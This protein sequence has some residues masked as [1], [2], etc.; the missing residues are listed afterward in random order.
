MASFGMSWA[1]PTAAPAAPD[2]APVA[3]KVA[4]VYSNYFGMGLNAGSYDKA[5]GGGPTSPLWTSVEEPIVTGERK[6]LKV[7]GTAFSHRLTKYNNRGVAVNSKDAGYTKVHVYVYPTTATT[8]YVYKDGGWDNADKQS[9]S[10]TPG[11]WNLVEFD[12]P[13]TWNANYYCVALMDDEDPETVFYMDDFYFTNDDSYVDDA[14][15]LGSITLPNYIFSATAGYNINAT[16]LD[17]DGA[18]FTPDA[19]LSWDGS[20]P[21]GAVINGKNIIFGAA[22]GAGIY[23]LQATDGVTTVSRKLGFVGAAPTDPTDAAGNVLAIFCGKYGTENY[24]GWGTGWEWGY[25]S[26]DLLSLGGNNCV[27]I[28]NV[29]TYGFPYPDAADLTQYTKLNFDVYTVEDV[30]GHVKIEG[31][32]ITNAEFTTTGGAW[33]HVEIDITSLDAAAGNKWIDF[34]FGANNT[35]KDRDVLID[36]IYFSKPAPADD[37]APTLQ[38]AELVG[39]GIGTVTLRLQATDN[40]AEKITYRITDQS[41]NVY[42]TKGNNGAEIT[43]TIGGLEFETAYNLTVVALDDNDNASTS[44]VVN[45]TTL[46]LTAPAA[47]TKPA[48]N[49]MSIY[50]DAYTPATTY[51]Y[52]GWG[53]STVVTPETVGGGEIVKLTNYNYLGFEYATQLDLHEMEYVHIDIL[54]M[55]TMDLGITP[56]LVAGSPTEKSTSVGA[57]TVGEWNSIDLPLSA[58]GMDFS[59]LS[60]QLKIDKGTGAE[61]VYID[62]IYFWKPVVGKNIYLD[63]NM[64]SADSPRYAA[65]AF[66]TEGNTWI[67]MTQ[68]GETQYYT[69]LIPEQYTGMSLVRLNPAGTLDWASKW[70]QT[71]DIPLG[72]IADNTM[73][74]ITS[75]DGGADSKSTYSTSPY[76]APTLFTANFKNSIGWEN[77]YAYTYGPETLGGWPGKKMTLNAG[78]YTTSFYATDAP[79]YIIFNNGITGEGKQQTGDLIFVDGNTYDLSNGDDYVQDT[80]EIHVNA[81]HYTGT[82]VYELIITSAE[83]ME[84]L[85]GS[86]WHING[87]EGSDLKTDILVSADKKA[88]SVRAT[89]TTAPALYTPL[90]V[91][92]PGEVNFGSITLNWV[93]NTAEVVTVSAAEWASY[94]STLDLDFSNVV[95]LTAYKATSNTA[96]SIHYEKVNDAAKNTG[97]VLNG[98]AR[99]YYVPVKGMAATHND[100]LLKGTANGPKTITAEE[101]ATNKFYAFGKVSEKIGFVKALSGYTVSQGK[102]YLELTAALAARDL[103]FIGLPGEEGDVTG[104]SNVRG[105]MSD[106]RGEYY[107]LAGQRVAQPTKGLYIVN[108]KKVIIK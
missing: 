70:N 80:H 68:V 96:T 62:N 31:T 95:G 38:V 94:S 83:D 61:T 20:S 107:N 104:I 81:Y 44:Q 51:N 35:D 54:P 21:V 13:D 4:V 97:L 58:F 63:P 53:Q 37:E 24:D 26:R 79:E 7:N 57:L 108:G 86:Y 46:A 17:T 103:D 75:W 16:L 18:E 102:A 59:N 85:G 8:V 69:A 19:T 99:T 32:T 88:I 29:G 40:V 64:W 30:S 2:P 47:P 42:S 90:Y 12:T 14:Q 39:T 71:V 101:A 3:R 74:T 78:V 72:E 76:V 56:I 48:A 11:Q 84:G 43:Y 77:V 67:E 100:N 1:Q 10:V 65:Y 25:T 73:F 92:M 23:N 98:V 9:K 22:S 93:E 15:V 87:S 82:N 33:K 55:Q 41:S 49:V 60:H 91:M 27:R 105:K 52:G 5:W 89:S 50:S 28:H 45:A 36:N 34:Y 106:V 66:N 6:V